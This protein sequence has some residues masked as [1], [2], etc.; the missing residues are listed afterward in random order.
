MILVQ[1]DYSRGE[2]ELAVSKIHSWSQGQKSSPDNDIISSQYHFLT[3]INKRVKMKVAIGFTVGRIECSNSCTS[4]PVM[5]AFEA[6][7]GDTTPSKNENL[8]KYN[9]S[10]I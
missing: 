6:D 9:K 10:K 5:A 3:P 4:P 8:A 2:L 7:S 1:M